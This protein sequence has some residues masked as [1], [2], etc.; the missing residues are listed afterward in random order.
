[1]SNSDDTSNPAPAGASASGG[2]QSVTR[3]LALLELVAAEGGRASVARLAEAS[4]LPLPT[5]HRLA[6][7]LVD[8]GYLRQLPDRRYAL[9]SRLI[10]LGRAAAGVVGLGADRVLRELADELG[11]TANLA[12]LTGTQAQYVAQA[13]GRHAMRMFTEVGR[14][15]DLHSTGVGKAMLAVLPERDVDRVVAEHPL[16]PRTERS[17]ASRAE[18]DAALARARANGY[19]LDDEEQELGVRC[20]AVAVVPRDPAA[21]LMALS[22][23]GPLQRM[24]DDA[25]ARAV[26]VLRAAAERLAG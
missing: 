16:R 10:G 2:V 20:V 4:G 24:S 21:A 17:L 3:A 12:V 23:S 15:V 1:M 11:E 6:R 7:T 9:A 5:A 22:A 26:P 19:A 8:A 25:I 13:P 18:L 14:L